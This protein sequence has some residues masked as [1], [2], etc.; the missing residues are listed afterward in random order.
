MKGCSNQYLPPKFPLVFTQVSKIVTNA[1]PIKAE[2]STANVAEV[3]GLCLVD[4]VLVLTASACGSV[5][6]MIA[7]S[8]RVGCL[9]AASNR[10]D[11][12]VWVLVAVSISGGTRVGGARP[13]G[14]RTIFSLVLSSGFDLSTL[15]ALLDSF[16]GLLCGLLP[17]LRLGNSTIGVISVIFGDL[18][19]RAAVVPSL[20][21]KSLE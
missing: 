19:P 11:K 15:D 8:V 16:D 10:L 5:Y 3:K 12:T 20:A 9:L 6:L 18:T 14:V 13:G 7:I 2:P 17:Q 21:L 1:T 4:A